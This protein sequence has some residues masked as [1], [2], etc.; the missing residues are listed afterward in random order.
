MKNI[1]SAIL[2]VLLYF[3][4]FIIKVVVL[5]FQYIGK[6]EKMKARRGYIVATGTFYS[7]NWI[8]THLKPLAD[9]EYCDRL[10]MVCTDTLPDISN[11][12]AAYPPGILV[13]IAG[14]SISR[15]IY[16]SW[17]T[18][19]YRPVFLVGFHLL[20]NGLAAIFLAKIFGSR[21]VYICGGG[22]REVAGGGYLTENAIFKRLGSSSLRIERIFFDYLRYCD[23]IVTMGS[24]VK[25][26][27][28]DNLIRPNVEVIAGGFDGEIYNVVPEL[29]IYDLIFIGRISNV[30]R[31][32][33][34]IEMTSI[35]KQHRASFK[36]AVLGDGPLKNDMEHL[37]KKY[38]LE[39]SIEFVGWTNDIVK[40]LRKSKLLILTSDSE[41]LSQSMIQAMMCGLPVVVSDV[42]DLGDLVIDGINGRLIDS[43]SPDEF[44]KAVVSILDSEH[45]FESMS[46]AAA[47][48]AALYAFESTTA[49]WNTVISKL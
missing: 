45:I 37:A 14:S 49:K 43:R 44:S 3:F 41:G 12:D 19:R 21:S 39:N 38:T 24:S 15:L 33:I 2:Q 47:K 1:Y 25:Q 35:I 29:K 46:K 20:L 30:K 6:S 18:I 40:W 34:L 42:G 4:L 5:V 7:D 22:Q 9:S 28:N 36:V 10:I 48:D 27:F 26:Y 8:I 23:L 11:V 31:L 17:L 32:D 13:K 16:F